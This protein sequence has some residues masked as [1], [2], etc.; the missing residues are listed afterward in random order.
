MEGGSDPESDPRFRELLRAEREK[1]FL[2]GLN[3]TMAVLGLFALGL[4]ALYTFAAVPRIREVFEQVKVP[5]PGLTLIVV[6]GYGVAVLVLALGS[7]ASLGI[8]LKWGDRWAAMIPSVACFALTLLW[9][10]LVVI[11]L[12]MPLLGMHGGIGHR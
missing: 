3:V 12:F 5:M 2:K 8:T 1:G 9:L 4:T 7:L 6:H 11:G 10:A